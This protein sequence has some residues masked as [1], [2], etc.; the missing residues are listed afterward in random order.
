MT[1]GLVVVATGLFL[2]WSSSGTRTRNSFASASALAD[3]LV[4][5]VGAWRLVLEVWPVV[6]P[7]LAVA[8]WVLLAA[9]QARFWLPVLVVALLAPTGVATALATRAESGLVRVD[10]TG[11]TAALV[12]AGV[13][14]LGATIRLLLD[15]H[16][17][18]VRIT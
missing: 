3:L 15:R 5:N 6:V 11:P 2:P 14:V 18:R 1:V 10:H 17:N 4:G 8:A 16:A 9:R 13:A 7:L 12:G